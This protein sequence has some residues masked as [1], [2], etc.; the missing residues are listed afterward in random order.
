MEPA[1]SA[2]LAAFRRFCLYFGFGIAAL[3]LLP[4]LVG[5]LS[6]PAGSSYL[7][8][9]YNTDDH[10]V[11]AAWMR[12]AMDG[13][14]FFDNRFTTDPQPGLTIHLYFLVLGWVAKAV[15]IPVAATLARLGFSILFV[16]LLGRL[17]ERLDPSLRSAKLTLALT[18][19]G[20]G[21]GF[22]FWRD[23]GV[24][25]GPAFAHGGLPIDAWQPEALVFP[26]MLTNSLFMV[27]L[28][29]IVVVFLAVLDCRTSWKPALWGALAFGVLMNIH[30]YDVLLIA[31]VLVGLLAMSIA[32]R[33]AEWKW[34]GRVAVIGFGA[35]PAALWF[36]YV[37]RSDPV[38]QARA[39]TETF[40]PNFRQVLLGIFP[41]LLFAVVFLYRSGAKGSARRV[42]AA[43]LAVLLG[44]L[45]LAAARETDRFWMGPLTWAVAM[46]AA[47]GVLVM[48]ASDS[49]ALDLVIAW[50][51][52]GLVAP[53]VPGL[54]QR[55][56][57]M[58]IEIPWCLLAGL[59]IG[60]I[61]QTMD[62][63]RR[64][65]V[66]A[67]VVLV[68]AGTSLRWFSREL[69]SIRADVSNTTV[70]PVFLTADVQRI[71]EV[72]GKEPGIRV[73]A[74][75]GIPA[76]TDD[77]DIYGRPYLPDLNPI[78][79]GLAGAYTYAGHWSETP[80]YVKRRSRVLEGLFLADSTTESRREV[81][82]RADADYV[83]SP[84]ADAFDGLPL[85]DLR[86]FGE[87]VYEG[88]Q[89]DLIRV[90]TKRTPVR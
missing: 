84:R 43:N 62:Q 42:G 78:L 30:S 18:C 63:G 17:V 34:V 86:P 14:V 26:S 77:P 4:A 28:C 16:V 36:L 31:L 72:L 66:G 9:Q 81:L 2:H 69:M 64:Q 60:H 20:G 45:A 15:G 71:V 73:I 75:P 8:F 67:L 6:A 80:D 68:F 85:A 12:Q 22:V 76:R 39:A 50:A 54:F 11:Y 65:M 35:I 32:R 82:E 7:G 56:L 24:A 79:S 88:T 48:L 47:I 3:A 55:K 33:R 40:S 61:M 44:V 58:G 52:I 10:M 51:V 23:Y 59:G 49:P 1:S 90:S 37:L 19:F 27:S 5:W 38:F 29:L 89:F 74:M 87:V 46:I 21:L 57:L 83:V 25:G 13:R 41:A 70:H 53:Y